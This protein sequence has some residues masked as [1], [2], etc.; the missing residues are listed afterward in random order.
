MDR[1]FKSKPMK[2]KPISIPGFAD[3]VYAMAYALSN[4]V[5]RGGH[6]DWDV[7]GAPTFVVDPSSIRDVL[8]EGGIPGVL[9]DGTEIW[10][11]VEYVVDEETGVPTLRQFKDVWSTETQTF[12]ESE[13]STLIV[14]FGSHDEAHG[15]IEE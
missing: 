14:A 11:R 13:T 3:G 1:F 6:I 9:P 7:W 15:I 5:M 12:T 8:R 10:G 4:M 2:G